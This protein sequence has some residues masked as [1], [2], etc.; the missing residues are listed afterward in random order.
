M[1]LNLVVQMQAPPQPA[2]PHGL[3]LAGVSE[4]ALDDERVRQALGGCMCGVGAGGGGVG[5]KGML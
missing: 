1:F 4:A 3:L 5:K 2:M